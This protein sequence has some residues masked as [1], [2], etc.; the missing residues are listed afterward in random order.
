VLFLIDGYN[1]M[2]A[3]GVVG[4]GRASH[5]TPARQRF[6]DWL[7]SAA[8]GRSETLRVV[9]DGQAA[10]ADSGEAAYRGLYVRFAYRATAD[11]EIE[12]ELAA[13]PRG[14]VVVV[15]NDGRLHEA[16]RRRGCA[17]WRCGRFVDWLI[18]PPPVGR[19]V[20]VDEEKPHDVAGDDEL[21]KA[22]AEPKHRPRR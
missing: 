3:A 13:L 7:A 21:L 17:A 14:G 12:A 8:H 5:L 9:F 20:D 1:L 4:H 11:D 22:F 19:A 18:E 6:L 2:H 10:P 15:S 16:A